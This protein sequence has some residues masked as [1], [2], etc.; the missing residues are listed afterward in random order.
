LNVPT[1][2]ASQTPFSAVDEA[3]DLADSAYY[4]VNVHIEAKAS[5]HLDA[6]KLR[7][8]V[9][10]ALQIHPLARA[11][12]LPPKP[13]D[14]IVYWEVSESAGIDPF[15]IVEGGDEAGV[16]RA[17]NQLLSIQVPLHEAPPLR[18]WLV[19]CDS[20]DH[21]ILNVHHAAADGIGTLRFLRS[22]LRAYNNEADQTGDV[23]AL[24]AR[25]LDQFYGASNHTEKSKRLMSFLSAMH[26]QLAERTPVSARGAIRRSGYGCCHLTVEAAEVAA[27][28]PKKHIDATFNDLLVAALHRTV[29]VWNDRQQDGAGL[30]R[31]MSP[32][33]LRPKEWW[34]E[35]FGNFAI[36]FATNSKQG[37]R[38][39]PEQ[40][41]A[42]ITEQSRVAKEKGFAESLLLGLSVNSKLPAWAKD[43]LFQDAGEKGAASAILTNAGRI[44]EALS[45]GDDGDAAEV[46]I[47][48][49]APM[50]DGLG[51]GVTNY[52]G[53]IHLSFRHSYEL[54]SDEAM[55]EFAELYRE[56]LHWLS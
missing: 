42:A 43:L 21:V 13:K 32:V 36:S 10:T 37:D 23:D 26:R 18:V 20:G 33:N 30:V 16:N 47:S 56:T 17:R 25:D 4:P 3:L 22:I 31:V 53:R 15:L 9:Q 52:N 49:P 55:A 41:M 1:V 38:K 54:L 14:K 24:E 45:F 8:A 40:L 6:E 28:N 50:P 5:R 27:L 29:E 34:F 46:W 11:F 51:I 35:V 7:A 19:R 12:K 44:G 48:P 39:S 2:H